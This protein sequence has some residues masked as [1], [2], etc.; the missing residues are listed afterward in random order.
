M[1]LARI[2][3]PG[4]R[5]ARKSAKPRSPRDDDVIVP[6][7]AA[8]TA[9]VNGLVQRGEAVRIAPGG[10]LPPGATHEIIGET[11]DGL[12]ILRRKRFALY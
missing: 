8:S 3:G 5:M 12:P 11:A 2:A 9:F 6:K 4:A 7:D 10:A 1:E